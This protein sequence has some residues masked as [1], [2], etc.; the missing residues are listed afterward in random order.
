MVSRESP[1]EAIN[2]L[3]S[4]FVDIGPAVVRNVGNSTLGL[5][6]SADPLFDYLI[7]RQE[8]TEEVEI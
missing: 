1:P 7:L 8:N 3:R 2:E 4:F 6:F 5:D